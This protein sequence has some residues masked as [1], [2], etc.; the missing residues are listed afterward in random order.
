M[1]ETYFLQRIYYLNCFYF[2][3]QNNNLQIKVILYIVNGQNVEVM[4]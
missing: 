4:I 2:I 1:H 3:S